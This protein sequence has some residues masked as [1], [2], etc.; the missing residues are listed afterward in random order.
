MGDTNWDDKDGVVFLFDGW[1]DVWL[2]VWFGDL[3]FMYDV[4][5][6]VMFCGY[7]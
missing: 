7:L 1:C 2:E 5:K 3:G 4:C 6:N